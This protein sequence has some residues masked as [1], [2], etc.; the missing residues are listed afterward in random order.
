M[1]EWYY[2]ATLSRYV[3]VKANGP[4]QARDQGQV[5]LP[6]PVRTVRLATA[7]EIGLMA[8]HNERVREEENLKGDSDDSSER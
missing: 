4:E 3:L 5:Q 8:W 1:S 2:V 7:G 6:T